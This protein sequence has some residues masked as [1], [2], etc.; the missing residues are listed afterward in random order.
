MKK[1]TI[2]IGVLLITIAGLMLISYVFAATP[3]TVQVCVLKTGYLQAITS[4]FTDKN[5]TK[6]GGYVITIGQGE[7]G[8]TGPKGPKGDTGKS[9]Y[10]IA[11]DYGFTGTIV[12]WLAS[13]VGPQGPQG[14]QGIQG[15]QG[16]QGPQGIQGPAGL[17]GEIGATGATGAKGDTGETGAT[18]ATGKSA[19]EVA[20]DNGF[21][22]SAAEWLAS[23][24]GQ[25]G[26]KGDK[27]DTGPAGSQGECTCDISR[28]ELED[29][30][31]QYDALLTRVAALEGSVTCVVGATRSCYTGSEGTENVGV[32]HAGAQTCGSG[33]VW[34]AC[35][36]DVI[37]AAET[38][39]G[40]DD[41][42]DGVVDEDFTNTSQITNC[43]ELQHM[44]DNEGG[45][46]V[47]TNDI[48]CS[49]TVNWNSGAG[50]EP[51]GTYFNG[52]FDGQDYKITG[53][54]I[55]RPSTNYVGLFGAVGSGAT[56]K[57]VGLVN[58]NVIG[59]N[60]TGGL[61][62]LNRSKITNSY[63]TGTVTGYNFVGGLIGHNAQVEAIITNS[64]ATGS[65]NGNGWVGGLVGNNP[66][67]II[68]N[69]YATGD[70][71]VSGDNR[72]GGGLV[73][74][75]DG[76]ITN[77]YATGDVTGSGYVGGLI[78]YGI[79]G[80]ITNSYATGSVNGS[81][82]VGGLI[83]NAETWA[84]ITNSYATG[85]VTGSGEVGGLVG[86]NYADITN[87][88]ATGSV[89]ANGW[90]G[91]LV[92]GN[93]GGIII[94]CYSIGSVSG[95]QDVGGLIG[96][97]Y[98]T[99]TNSY[100]DI[101]T[102][103]QTSSA[104]GEGKTTAE[105]KTKSTFVDWDFVTVWNICEGATYP[106]LT[107]Q[108]ITCACVP[109]AE[110]CD[111][112]DN[113]C[114]PATADGS[115]DPLLGVACDGPDADLCK[116]GTYSCTGG[117][118]VCS[119][120]TGSTV[121][122][123]ANGVD[124]DCNG[125]IDEGCGGTCYYDSGAGHY[126]AGNCLYQDSG[127]N[128]Q[129][130]CSSLPLG[131]ACTLSGECA[132]GNCV[133]GYCCNSACTG[134]CQSCN[135]AYNT[136]GSGTCSFITSGIDPYAEC[137]S[138]QTCDGSGACTAAAECTTGQTRTC[139]LQLGV[140]LGS[141]E[142]CTGNAWPGCNYGFNYEAGTETNCDGLDNDCDGTTDEGTGGGICDG[143]D[144]DLCIDDVFVCSA[145]SLSCSDVGGSILEACGDGIDN[146]CD[147]IVDEGCGC[148]YDSGAGHYRAG[149]CL[150][151][152]SGCNQQISC[153]SLPLG[154]ACTSSGEC[155]S[156]NC[157]DGYCCNGACSSSCDSCG[158]TG[159]QG[160]CTLQPSGY[161]GSPSCSPYVC[162]GTSASCP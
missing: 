114:N 68:T 106:S 76:N 31:A 123:C 23:L 2:T 21:Y 63:S 56:I 73:G 12:E 155:A 22:G 36:G 64:Y 6:S 47:L 142:T 143:P 78:G 62:G 121:E 57:N 72:Y 140:C 66:G 15:P 134:T 119:D 67:G 42:C 8:P 44:K 112:I 139:S 111:G 18:G 71:S 133:D 125:S 16:E 14:E 115:A 162:D 129:I 138:G 122:I 33:G 51:V 69:S 153:S 141:H 81:G 102:S 41:D 158:L 135:G 159:F 26:D 108:G 50:F 94:N 25:K 116:E 132:S 52:T 149:N 150:Y 131:S 32:C 118:L 30:Q 113:D 65:V 79:G 58:V 126:R 20:L 89:N 38:C 103:G 48:D 5:C 152:D 87:S 160:N 29:L 28:T 80:T 34:G 110:V 11:V 98:A 82:L 130:S 10:E 137:G 70:V 1:K 19:F 85:D 124:D 84:D 161:P 3:T 128:Q 74:F 35:I 127:C 97:N 37:P 117:S 90:V 156:G 104:G 107:W 144:S 4:N 120:T 91:G 40:L 95:T 93:R 13:L 60:A 46:Y 9:A 88:Y 27:G 55:N 7:M 148:Y 157:V 43:C 45:V 53:L 24:I 54:Y 92:G 59:Q 83:G 147:G 154:S 99:I 146:D 17:Q 39:N 100:W 61:V 77:S 49:S 86:R 136:G 101:D 96:R 109:S 105:M 75:S 151:Q 145:G